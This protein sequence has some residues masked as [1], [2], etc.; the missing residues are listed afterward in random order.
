MDVNSKQY[1]FQL[2]HLNEKAGYVCRDFIFN[3]LSSDSRFPETLMTVTSD[4][5]NLYIEI[6]TVPLQP[7]S[8]YPGTGNIKDGYLARGAESRKNM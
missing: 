7:T 6:S 3:V 5:I 8:S 1:N 2:R 4:G